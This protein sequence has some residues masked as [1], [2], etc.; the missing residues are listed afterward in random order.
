MLVSINLDLIVMFRRV[1]FKINFVSRKAILR[2][3]HVFSSTN[4]KKCEESV[5]PRTV[6]L[7][8]LWEKIMVVL[9]FCPSACMVL[10]SH[11][12]SFFYLCKHKRKCEDE[13]D[14]FPNPSN[15]HLVGL[16][17]NIMV[18]F[19]RFL[20]QS[21]SYAYILTKIFYKQLLGWKSKIYYKL[22]LPW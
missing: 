13:G 19:M 14:L 1:F 12:L 5:F 15:G 6:N 3:R 18:L 7:S 22:V 16:W 21:P 4:T 20:K 10:T 17:E 9:Q 11:A 8:V 2:L